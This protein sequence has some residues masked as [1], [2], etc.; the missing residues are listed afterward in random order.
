MALGENEPQPD[1]TMNNNLK[2]PIPSRDEVTVRQL[3]ALLSCAAT[4]YPVLLNLEPDRDSHNGGAYEA[5]EATFT[6]ICDRID[7]IIDDPKR[8]SLDHQNML[9][10]QLSMLYQEHI[11]LLTTQKA[12]TELLAAP[13]TIHKPKL[14]KLEDQTWVAILGDL[15]FPD[16]CIVGS[17]KSPAEALMAWD[18]VFT[19]RMQA[20]T[21]EVRDEPKKPARQPRKNNGK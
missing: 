4:L 8:W 16:N 21:I 1:T 17:G 14:M 10:M 18:M 13:H 11:N 2:V 20:Q 6:K 3:G 9:E 7:G 5:A 12:A 15:Q 19:G